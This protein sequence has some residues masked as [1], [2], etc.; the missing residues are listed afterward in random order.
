MDGKAGQET[1]KL[2]YS[3]EAMTAE[4]GKV[5]NK[6]KM[7]PTPGTSAGTT[8]ATPNPSTTPTP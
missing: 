4:V 2:L 6:T 8:S 3:A 7:T 1:L 5:N